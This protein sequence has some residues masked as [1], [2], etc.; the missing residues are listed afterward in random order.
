MIYFLTEID[1]FL[2]SSESRFSI[3]GSKN[4]TL[5]SSAGI[6]HLISCRQGGGTNSQLPFSLPVPKNSYKCCFS[7]SVRLDLAGAGGGK[8]ALGNGPPSPLQ[9]PS[10]LALVSVVPFAPKDRAAAVLLPSFPPV[11]PP[12]LSTSIQQVFTWSFAPSA[13][14]LLNV[15]KARAPGLKQKCYLGYGAAME[16]TCITNLK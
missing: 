3:L 7:H 5:L 11:L 16:L 14:Q 4:Y 2:Y 13:A 1:S 9:H 12:P 6:F 8:L 15:K 10:S